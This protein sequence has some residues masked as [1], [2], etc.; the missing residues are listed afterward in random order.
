MDLYSIKVRASKENKHISG[1][2]RIVS[3][4]N[5]PNV[6]KQLLE[7]QQNKDFDFS[8]IKIEKLKQEPI[9]IEKSLKIVQFK[10]ENYKKSLKKAIDILSKELKKDENWIKS[11]IE[12]LYKGA[13]ENGENLKGAMI[14]DLNGNRLD[15]KGIRTVLVDFVDREKI[16]EKLEKNGFTKR[17]VDALALTTKN[18]NYPNIVAEFCISDDSDYTIGYVSTKKYYYRFIP[19]KEYQLDKGGR[20]Y[21]V[22]NDTN[23]E[24]LIKYLRETP[25]LIKDVDL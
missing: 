16:T 20:I 4:E 7:R 15:E 3:K 5:I 18:L 12:L 17:T 10:Y 8:N 22:K 2:E 25:V 19:L 1:S 13:G 21:F 6:V 23:K 24:K 11:Y 14:I 9:Y